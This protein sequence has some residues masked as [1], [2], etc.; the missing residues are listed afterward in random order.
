MGTLLGN[1]LFSNK[2]T[3]SGADMFKSRTMYRKGPLS[4]KPG[5]FFKCM[6]S[7]YGGSRALFNVCKNS[8]AGASVLSR[9]EHLD[10]ETES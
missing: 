8:Q 5:L 10:F 2:S 6:D 4:T 9:D 3:K 7:M 1:P